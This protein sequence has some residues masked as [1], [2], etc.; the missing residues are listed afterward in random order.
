MKKLILAVLLTALVSGGLFA[1]GQK[2]SSSESTKLKG[3]K[4][5]MV[6]Q[7]LTNQ[8]WAERAE[9][10]KQVVESNGGT[11]IYMGADSNVGKQIDLIENLVASGIDI[12][13]V[14]PTEKNAINNALKSVMDK[15][16]KVFNYD[17]EIENSDVNFLLDN[18]KAGYMIGTTAANWIN[19]MLGGEAEVAILDWPQIEI[20]LER[21]N[22]IED[23]LRDIAPKAKIVAQSAALNPTQGMAKTETFFQA[24]PNI[25]VIACIGGGAAVGANE[26][27]KASGKLTNDFGIFASDATTQELTAIKN[28][29]AN[30][31]SI[32]YT[33]TAMDNA[34]LIYTWLEKLYKG[35][36]V[37]RN[38]FHVFI[39][40][41][42]DNYQDYL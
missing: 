29:E 31:S 24:N 33:G 21:G 28:N 40:V 32:M 6:L 27:V 4:V 20:L 15:G 23:A 36:P 30:R 17:S 7:D 35:E 16:V 19:E 22:G 2:E 13:M 37:D 18:Y 8:V 5:G 3:M 9:A 26:A 38:V 10:M 34:E 11:L 41:N 25:K 42:K 39:P 12:L 1:N 14:H